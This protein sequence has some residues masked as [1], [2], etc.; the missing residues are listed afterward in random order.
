MLKTKDD[1]E[2][3][4]SKH[5][6]E[7]IF[8]GDEQHFIYIEN[9]EWSVNSNNEVDTKGEVYILRPYNSDGPFVP[10]KFGRV[11]GN[12][13]CVYNNLRNLDGCPREVG[14]E[15]NL[16]GNKLT[17]LVGAPNHVKGR[18]ICIEND[19]QTTE[20]FE[21]KM[22]I[23]MVADLR[24]AQLFGNVS[25]VEGKVAWVEPQ[26]V[27]AVTATNKEKRI[28]GEQLEILLAPAPVPAPGSVATTTPAPK[29]K[30]KI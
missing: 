28:I 19:I 4:L 2:N 8:D 20:G 27:N 15:F 3:W 21:T 17:S 24:C 30:M 5:S 11:G 6:G 1:I 16:K 13:N 23:G 26:T 7:N 25:S 29:R 22:G 9:G 14:G 10:F 18:F 12:F